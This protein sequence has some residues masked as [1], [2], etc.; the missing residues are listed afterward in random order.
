MRTEDTLQDPQQMKMRILFIC[1]GNICRSPAAQTVMQAMVDGKGLSDRYDID[2]AGI[3]NWHVGQL[4]DPRMRHTAKTR[5]YDITHRARQFDAERDFERFDLIVT[6]D[7]ENYRRITSMAHNRAER[8]RVVAM[9]DYL[10]DH[11]GAF[12]VP[13]PYY[14]SQRDFDHALDLIEDGCAGLLAE[15]ERRRGEED[16]KKEGEG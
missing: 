16:K 5:G 9:A 14:G 7:P 3:G 8:R 2:S 13:D 10:R 12:S 11:R 6:M 1:L 4:A 15:I